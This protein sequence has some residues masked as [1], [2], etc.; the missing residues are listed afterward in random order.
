MHSSTIPEPSISAAITRSREVKIPSPI[1]LAGCN[2]ISFSFGSKVL[3]KAKRADSTSKCPDG[4]TQAVTLVSCACELRDRVNRATHLCIPKVSIRYNLRVRPDE[5]RVPTLVAVRGH[6]YLWFSKSS[7]LIYKLQHKVLR[8]ARALPRSLSFS[9]L[10]IRLDF[11]SSCDSHRL[12]S[13]PASSNGMP[14]AEER[15][16]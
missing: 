5:Q 10:F 8:L 14:I 4:F 15:D 7:G 12:P 13:H 11:G 6:C 16:S 2:V 9:F 3:G 1:L